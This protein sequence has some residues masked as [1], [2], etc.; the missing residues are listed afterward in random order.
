MCE[1]C[2]NPTAHR[3]GATECHD[4][5]DGFGCVLSSLGRFNAAGYENIAIEADQFV[6]KFGKSLN[7][8]LPVSVLDSDVS[9]LGIAE[10]AQA[11][12]K[13]IYPLGVRRNAIANITKSRIATR[14][15]TR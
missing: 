14:Q 6:S 1:T 3:I 8:T 10:F 7:L 2:D 5:G 15:L 4:D 12:A 9:A 13:F 11:S